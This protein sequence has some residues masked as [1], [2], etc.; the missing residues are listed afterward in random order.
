MFSKII[1][2]L[3]VLFAIT[4]AIRI[5][6]LRH[7]YLQFVEK[8]QE[9]QFVIQLM[10]YLTLITFFSAKLNLNTSHGKVDLK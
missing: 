1:T 6:Y 10:P 7:K 4:N 9:E 3:I 8:W 5:K 2:F